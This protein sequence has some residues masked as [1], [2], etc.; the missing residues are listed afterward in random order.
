MYYLNKIFVLFVCLGFAAQLNA[1]TVYKGTVVPLVKNTFRGGI[2]ANY[3]GYLISAARLGK[4][5]IPPT[6]DLKGDLLEKGSNVY[7]MADTFD[8][9]LMIASEADCFSQKRGYEVE[10]KQYLRKKQLFAEKAISEQTYITIKDKYLRTKAKYELQL[11]KTNNWK[12]LLAHST[13]DAPFEGIISKAYYSRGPLTR[14]TKLVEATMLNPIGIEVKMS[15]D[16]VGQININTPISV[17]IDDGKKTIGVNNYYSIISEDGIIFT[18]ENKP[19]RNARTDVPEVRNCFPVNKFSLAANS[20]KDILSVP[21]DVLQKDNKGY[22]VWRAIDRKMMQPGKGLNPLFKVESVYVVPG[23]IKYAY[24]GDLFLQTLDDPGIL[25][26][27]D[28]VVSNPPKGLEKDKTISFLPQRYTL[29]PG[30]TVKVV[31]GDPS[32][33]N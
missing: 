28:V 5:L 22:Y 8:R 17:Q 6:I 11:A 14:G 15:S 2:D 33:E 9:G 25:K 4:I 32:T 10:K 21:I 3:W 18:T 31:V 13:L 16:K 1:A 30:D 19:K 26:E 29:M 12:I 20:K 7:R 27:H 24:W 23:K